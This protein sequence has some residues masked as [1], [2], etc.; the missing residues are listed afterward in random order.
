MNDFSLETLQWRFLVLKTNLLLLIFRTLYWWPPGLPWCDFTTVVT[1]SSLLLLCLFSNKLQLGKIPLTH[2]GER[3]FPWS[4]RSSW[5]TD[6]GHYQRWLGL[7]SGSP[8]SSGP[9]KTELLSGARHGC[10]TEIP[11][12]LQLSCSEPWHK[13]PTR[14][15]NMNDSLQHSFSLQTEEAKIFPLEAY[16]GRVHPPQQ[17]AII[18]HDFLELRW[19]W[20]VDATKNR[21]SWYSREKCISSGWLSA[22][23]QLFFL[24]KLK[25]HSWSLRRQLLEIVNSGHGLNIILSS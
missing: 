7:T 4:E 12:V 20:T 10:E 11:R 16:F 8:V 23:T 5:R 14:P 24:L 1:T 22:K 19:V 9:A 3:A 2:W 15:N 21:A 18:D 25:I 13:Q 17:W 6:L